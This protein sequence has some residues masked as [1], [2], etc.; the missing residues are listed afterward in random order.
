MLGEMLY[1]SLARCA[2]GQTSRLRRYAGGA[3]VESLERRQLLTGTWTSLAAS[4]P[5]GVGTMMLLPDGSVLAQINGI[6][7]DWAR[8]QPDSNGSYVNGS[9]TRLASAHDTRLYDASQVLPN[10]NV[11]V[12][13]GEYGTGSRTGEIY[14]PL[15]NAWTQLP[16]QN[17]GNFLDC[18]SEL[19]PD[20]RVLI[21][22]VSPNPGG[23]TTIF[24]PSTNSWLQGPRL[25]RGGSAD[26]QSWVKL[27]DGSILS[28]DGPGTSERYIPS[29]N[30]WVNDGAMPVTLWDS[31]GEIGAGV[32]LADGRA[33]FLGASGH[34]ALYTPSG[35]SSPGVWAAGPDIPNGKGQPDA[36]AA[37]LPDGTVLCAVGVPG[38]YNGPTS[39]YLYDPTANSF[40]LVPG[41][42]ALG[43]GPYVD[44]MLDLPDGTVLFS[45]G[46]GQVYDYAPNTTPLPSAQPVITSAQANADG[47]YQ[48]TGTLF[49]GVTE[50]AAYGDDA[51]MSSNYPIV[52]F[53]DSTGAVRFARSFNWSST[54][55]QTGST[56]V[57]TQYVL[58]LGIAAGVYSVSVVT[59][60]VS[61]AAISLTVPAN[62]NATVPS[63]SAP[64]AASATTVTGTTTD[65]S[66]LG[67]DLLD[68]ESGLTYTWTTVSAPSGAPLPSLS[69][70]GNNAAKHASATFY[71]A[72]NYTF[73][74][75]ITNTAGL[76][77]T[78]SLTLTVAQT[79]SALTISPTV[80]TLSAGHVQQFIATAK[81]QF[82]QSMAKQPAFNWSIVSGGGTITSK[83]LYTA[84]A[85]GTLATV[86]AGDGNQ[87]AQVT[88]GVVSAPWS[89]QDVG[90]VG[91]PGQAYNSGNTFTLTGSGSDIWAASD[92]FRYVYQ[93]VTGDVS[94]TA[95]VTSEQSTDPWAKVG[96]MIR[97]SLDATDQFAFMDITPGNGASFQYRTSKGGSASNNNS[98]SFT[99]PYWV[100]L[101]RSGNVITGYRSADGLNWTAQGSATIFMGTAVD[102]GLEVCSHNNSLRN[103]ST[104]D[105]VMVSQPSVG[106][107]ASASPPAISGTSAS[108]S[109]LG[110][111]PAGESNLMYTWVA[112]S[113]PTGA[114]RPT[115]SANGTNAAKDT[116]ATLAMAGNYTFQVTISD[117]AGLTATSSVNVVANQ[118]LTSIAMTP[119]VNSVPIGG[120]ITI[121]ATALDQ[122]GNPMPA[123]PAFSWSV[124]GAANSITNGTLTAGGLAGV[125]TVSAQAGTVSASTNVT[126]NSLIAGRDIFYN[127][128]VFDRND[129]SINVND[130][131]TIAADKQALL[132]GGG[133]ATFANYTNYSKG[134]NGIMV[135]VAGLPGTLTAADFTFLAGNSG[136]PGQWTP[137]PAPSAVLVRAG[138]GAGGSARIEI[139]WP[140]GSIRN[141][142]LQVTLNA[143]ANT[144]LAAPDV[145]YF[146]NL[147]GS[148][149]FPATAGAFTVTPSDMTSA[150]N[151]PHTFLSPASILDP[152]DFNRD[153]RVDAIDQLIARAQTG[154][155]LIVLT[156]TPP[157]QPTPNPTPAQPTPANQPPSHTVIRTAPRLRATTPRSS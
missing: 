4:A 31:I 115:F 136:T 13:G 120:S 49:N 114:A 25:Y 16:A 110:S 48:L 142:W 132:P 1:Q 42:P 106:A 75:T 100:R 2:R 125:F 104:F 150:R 99:A 105:N 64:A 140:D 6:S 153:G 95:R 5:G 67:S 149:G 77:T 27:P 92:Q 9:W 112:T 20:G 137:A 82:G 152:N 38:S 124:T 155:S 126:I 113:V 138:A 3:I 40:S 143:N 122:F 62:V 118:T 19:L 148:A 8:L 86:G 80:A 102:I 157:A 54:G 24:D 56:L 73:A 69:T 116:V 50:G 10:G 107:A 151:D 131:L 72:G 18:G 37:V 44:R 74:A 91:L 128:S 108:L 30:Q 93:T 70:N 139:T 130:D 76:S 43:A 46:G 61:S 145:F 32:L 68:P 53:T 123:Q 55:V 17:F 146:G 66:V 26:E 59:N 154:T 14:N 34:T 97:N 52:R 119:S 21:A 134:I 78:S 90:A 133:S 15:T 58:P 121:G 45:S 79:E 29:L 156:P 60:G 47:T 23:S 129:P 135:D 33:F 109:V 147:A 117:P 39:I 7:A 35:T 98:G 101:V 51:Q 11:F 28:V 22:P 87:Q 41:S 144:G 88:C 85:A 71:R 83:G 103:T 96:V 94:I 89:S 84:P 141:Q 63:I 57:S 81:D 65:L 12:A 36:P 127:N 111:D